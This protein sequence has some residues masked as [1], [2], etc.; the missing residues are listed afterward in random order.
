[1]FA[2][3]PTVHQVAIIDREKRTVLE[4]WPVPEPQGN[5][6]IA[7]DET[8]HRLFVGCRQPAR[9]VVFDTSTGKRVADVV[10]SGDTDDLFYDARHGR[11]YVSCGEGFVDIIE[12]LDAD[13]YRRREQ[14]SAVPGARTSTFSLDLNALFLGVPR[15][16]E[17]AA[18]IR[19][20]L[21]K[22]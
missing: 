1:M 18:E 22:E 7:L 9:L 4:P 14:I 2:N 20:F 13:H 16:G 15:R 11:I 6:P 17:Q 8:H 12:Q 19:V 10:I 21:A 3:L 5:T